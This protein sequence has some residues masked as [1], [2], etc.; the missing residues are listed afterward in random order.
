MGSNPTSTAT[1][2]TAAELNAAPRT[3]ASPGTSLRTAG[4][5]RPLRA[6]EGRVGAGLCQ[7]ALITGQHLGW[8]PAP[9]RAAEHLAPALTEL[10]TGE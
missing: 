8:L 9:P 3:R 7:S 6:T 2:S 1:T 10:F 5:W 4:E